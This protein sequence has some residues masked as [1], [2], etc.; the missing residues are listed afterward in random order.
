[1]LQ[2]YTAHNSLG[3]AITGTYVPGSGSMTIVETEDPGGG[4]IVTI[5]G[6]EVTLQSKTATPST[7]SQVITPSSGYTGL[8]Q[9]TVNPIPS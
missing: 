8:S 7:S 6:T 4:T 3:Q 9:V 5:T 1:L 2:G